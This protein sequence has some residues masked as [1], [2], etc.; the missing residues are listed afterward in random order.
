[1]LIGLGFY[2]MVYRVFNE[3]LKLIYR[4]IYDTKNPQ[5]GKKITLKDDAIEEAYQEVFKWSKK[6]EA[7]LEKL[8]KEEA[9]IREFIGNISH[10][11]KT[12]VFTV[13]GYLLTLLDGGIDDKKNNI[14]FLERAY[15]GVE[16]ITRIVEDLDIITKI[17]SEKLDITYSEFD[18]VELTQD[19][20]DELE[21]L[22]K[23]KN[24]SIEFGKEPT[25]EILVNADKNRIAQ[26]LSNLITNSIH[27]GKKGGTT[28]I[29]FFE[30]D[31][32]VL[33]E[34][35]DNGDGIPQ[36]YLPRLFERFYRV[37]KSRS[38]NKGG[39]G[40]GLAI[41]KHFIEAHGHS[42]NVRSTVGVGSTFSFTLSK[43]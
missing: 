39:T 16:R 1:M 19:I 40:L 14:K 24:I 23:E 42:V 22:A 37:E 17:E 28:T 2:I 25:K 43:A 30:I 15:N 6:S 34:V 36:E 38:R 3:K 31:D 4:I 11:L 29:R 35:A 26:V 7:E 5:K 18:I 41:V 10:E 33:V 21:I 32:N 13:Q 20:M 12:P 27:Y 8:K 9:F